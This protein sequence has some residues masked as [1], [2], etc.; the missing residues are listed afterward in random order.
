[1]CRYIYE[2]MLKSEKDKADH[3][4]TWGGTLSIMKSF[5]CGHLDWPRKV[6]VRTEGG[7]LDSKDWLAGVGQWR[8]QL[9]VLASKC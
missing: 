7:D 9:E 1:M 5:R 8:S 3:D 6:A 2:C 4:D